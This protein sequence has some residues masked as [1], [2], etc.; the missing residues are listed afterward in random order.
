MAVPA[1]IIVSALD[2]LNATSKYP[3]AGQ[4]LS[5]TH[6]ATRQG[7][8][9]RAEVKQVLMLSGAK[10]NYYHHVVVKQLPERDHAV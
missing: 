9:L 3:L 6:R 7:L 8:Q 4:I 10:L 2:F 1:A 5:T